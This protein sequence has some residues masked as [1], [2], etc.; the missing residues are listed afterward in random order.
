MQHPALYV[1][2]AKHS[3]RI[4]TRPAQYNAMK[5]SCGFTA[6]RNGVIDLNRQ[7][8]YRTAAYVTA[9]SITEKFFGFLYRVILSRTLG[10]EGMGLYQ[11]ALS[12]FAVLATAAASGIPLTVSR[13]ITKYRAKNNRN[14]Q[15]SVVSA[16]LVA[17]LCF[18]VPT[19]CIL[20]FGHDLFDFIFSDPR[21]MS[22]LL[23]LL[24]SLTFNSV[25][26][27][28]R[29]ALWGNKQFI[30]YCVIDLVEELTMMTAGVIL[31][32]GMSDVFDGAK[33]IAFA[34]VL[35]YLVSFTLSTAY[36]FIKGGRLK[37]PKHQLKPLLSSAIPITGM[38]TSNSLINSAISLLL[39]ARLI[40]AGYTSAEAVSEIGVAMGMSMPILS[41]PATLIGS[42]ALVMVP[43]LAENFFRG[44]HAK[45]RDNIEKALKATVL[46]ACLLIPLLFVLGENIG[47][48]LFSNKHGGQIIR[49][50]S[51]MLLPMSVGMITTSILNSL[52]YEKQTCAYFFIGAAVTLSCVW[53][54]PRFAG[55]YALMIGMAASS[56]VSAV[57]NLRLI[58]KKSKEKVR[59]C[60]HTL[61]SAATIV[62]AS[63]F[64]ILTLNMLSALL[65]A[66]AAT[67]L[68]AFILLSAHALF[69]FALGLVRPRWIKAF[70]RRSPDQT[71]F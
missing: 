26:S 59:F 58:T 14:A 61:I 57:L 60:K 36:F 3:K 19:F 34:I 46:I 54:L 53:F 48:L 28:L 65:P 15:Q 17:A 12:V 68:C 63:L 2:F 43:E 24:P 7:N 44:Q 52:G 18:S 71:K 11:I 21:C 23:I 1:N 13:L 10:S 40:A 30:P 16:A 42:L 33:R 4:F 32:T 25:Y 45:L 29:G 6:A 49:F 5:Q 55:V 41:I 51:F 47:I 31:V 39:P 70:V 9:F 37:N 64:G 56:I 62:P 50:S 35:S 66:A 69:L 8:I 22:I 27:V 20:F 38:R 67:V